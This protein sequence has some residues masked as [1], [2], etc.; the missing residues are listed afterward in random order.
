LK[1]KIAE[2]IPEVTKQL[3]PVGVVTLTIAGYP[4][5]DI[6]QLAT[7]VYIIIQV[8]FLLRKN[9]ERYSTFINWITGGKCGTNLKGE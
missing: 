5:A 3:P 6:V 4:I 9:S 2:V 8:H 7:L 1:E